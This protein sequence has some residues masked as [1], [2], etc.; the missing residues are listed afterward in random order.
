MAVP[1][2]GWIWFLAGHTALVP[3]LALEASGP[4]DAPTNGYSPPVIIAWR[5]S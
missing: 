1:T 2:T 5:T 4:S 3:P